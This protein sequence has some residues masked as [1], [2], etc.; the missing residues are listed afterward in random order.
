[1]KNI[2]MSMAVFAMMLSTSCSNEELVQNQFTGAREFS[3]TVDVNAGS[4]TVMDGQVNIWDGNDAV[5]VF[6]A[7]GSVYGVLSIDMNTLSP[8]GRTATFRGTVNGDADLRH[9]VFPAPKDNIPTPANLK[10]GTDNVNGAEHNAPMYGE[11]SGNNSTFE[12]LGGLVKFEIEGVKENQKLAFEANVDDE[13]V[14]GGVY[15]WDAANNKLVYE[16]TG[17]TTIVTGLSDQNTTV[18]LPVAVDID[19]DG[20]QTAAPKASIIANL[21]D[22]DNEPVQ[23]INEESIPISKGDIA[24]TDGEKVTVPENALEGTGVK[25]VEELNQAITEGAYKI[26]LAG[27]LQDVTN[28]IVIPENKVLTIDLNGFGIH[29]NQEIWQS[30]DN[31]LIIVKRGATLTINDSS[32]E[33]KGTIDANEVP[34]VYAAVQ[35]TKKGES[36]D[37]EVASL[38]VNG[39]TLKGYY[40]GVTGNGLRHNTSITINDG[41]LTGYAEAD[42]Y[43][44]YHPQNGTL[45]VNGGKFDGEACAVEL[46]S[47]TMIIN[48][49]IFNSTAEEYSVVEN[50]D[51]TTAKGAAIAISQHNTNLP[52]NVTIRGGVYTGMKS[53]VEENVSSVTPKSINVSIEGG[54]FNGPVYSEN[55]EKFISACTFTEGSVF[56]Y[57]A[58]EV[59]LDMAGDVKM[60]VA[61]SDENYYFGTKTTKSITIEGNENTLTLNHTNSGWNCIRCVNDDAK[62]II[63]D[64]NL[65]NS[66][67]NDG[68]WDRHD[69]RF[70]NQVEL[71]DVNSDKAIALLNGADLTNVNI[72]DIH[73]SNSEMYG[74][75]IVPNGQTVNITGGSIIAH[76]S[77][78][79][80]RGITVNNQYVSEQ[81]GDVTLNVTGTKFETQKK[82]AIHVKFDNKYNKNY[83]VKINIT[84]IDISGVAYDKV[85]AVSVDEDSE[86]YFGNVT[87]TGGTKVQE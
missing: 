21:Y 63:N 24:N 85:N 68:P 4:R 78:S 51:G 46:R 6:S 8:D 30:D 58:D 37:G 75:W 36:A 13:P 69:I 43:G 47:G 31:A 60:D 67:H 87:V 12:Y 72:S 59:V 23:I 76:S 41:Y 42:S 49:G 14:T 28:T 29:A 35:L 84:G 83:K 70:Y 62:W 86:E 64:V 54:T 11:I 9:V 56:K 22:G 15:R 38:I 57:I 20:N 27:H 16:A 65:T 32:A 10:I 77:K 61:A 5:Y 82:G 50:N 71:T 34:N 53:F 45:T 74:I 40:Y 2:M 7:D 17:T 39:G 18:Y 1:M 66:G 81:V 48:D 55:C 73:S 80:D 79:G 52:I 19:A 3:L 44:I 25:T 33:E 26:I